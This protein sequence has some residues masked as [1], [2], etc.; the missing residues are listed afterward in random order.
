MPTDELRRFLQTT[1]TAVVATLAGAALVTA[2]VY[3]IVGEP[4]MSSVESPFLIA[5]DRVFRADPT[6]NTLFVGSSVTFRQI[7]PAIFDAELSDSHRVHSY[8]LGNDGLYAPRSIDFLEY[9]LTTAP[10]NLDTVF[11]ELFRLDEIMANYNAPEIMH[12]TGYREF[13]EI[14]QTIIA[15]NFPARYKLWLLAQYTRGFAYKAFGFGLVNYY[16]LERQLK[17]QH[18]ER[19]AAADRGFYAKDVELLQSRDPENV[20]ALKSVRATLYGHPDKLELRRQMHVDKYQKQWTVTLNPFTR[21]LFELIDEAERQGIRLVFVLPPLLDLRGISFAYPVWLALPPNHRL[22][23]SD[24]Q[25][26]PELYDYNHLFDLEHV[27][28]VGS[29]WF[30]RY[31]AEAYRAQ[32][33]AEVEAANE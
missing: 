1:G 29:R 14:S 18:T 13:V 32:L 25:R 17:S 3:A 11:V 28:S 26:F 24:P 19:L 15:A 6:F 9:L 27:N 16:F 7:D 21:R 33:N 2:G 8:N 5:K 22:D 31:L 23:L 10:P 4:D 12:A 30:T 20:A